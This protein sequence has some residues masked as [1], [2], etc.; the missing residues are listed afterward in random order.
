MQGVADHKSGDGIFADEA[1]DGLEVGSIRGAMNRKEGLCGEVELIGEGEADAAVAYVEG[2]RCGAWGEFSGSAGE[3]LQAMHAKYAKLLCDARD[4]WVTLHSLLRCAGA[5][6]WL[7]PRVLAAVGRRGCGRLTAC[8]RRFGP[9]AE[10]FVEI[11]P[12]TGTAG[13]AAQL[14]QTGIVRSKLAFEGAEAV[15]RG[16]VEGRGVPVRPSGDGGRGV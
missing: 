11:A 3:T 5:G 15:P 4:S 9:K 6:S 1:A 2:L 7:G 10:R 8:S 13:I 14:E 16:S 12:G